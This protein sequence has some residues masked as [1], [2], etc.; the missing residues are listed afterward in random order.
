MLALLVPP[1][2]ETLS[3]S[4]AR[5]L[6][7]IGI[8][9]VLAAWGVVT[10]VRRRLF[11]GV[12]GVVAAVT[13]MLVGPIVHLAPEIQGPMLWIVL[14][15]LGAA[16]IAIATS[17]ERGRAHLAAALGRLDELLQGWE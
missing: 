17:I 2:V 15:V 12:S 9:V 1:I 11:V 7:A 10:R 14:A 4:P 8:G 6:I 5:G 16:L 13:L 3:R